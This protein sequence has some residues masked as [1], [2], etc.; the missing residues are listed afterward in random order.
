MTGNPIDFDFL[1]FITLIGKNA[2][3]T[4]PNTNCS[5]Y[6]DDELKVFYI[7]EKVERLLINYDTVIQRLNVYRTQSKLSFSFVA[8]PFNKNTDLLNYKLLSDKK[9]IVSSNKLII[10]LITGKYIDRS[11]KRSST[12]INTIKKFEDVIEKNN[13][14][15]AILRQSKH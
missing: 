4:N 8:P 15:K 1:P 5:W 10:D 6:W 12:V 14:M 13:E 7:K 9:S 3:F 2:D 11:I